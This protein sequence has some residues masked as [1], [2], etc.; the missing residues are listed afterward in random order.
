M[1]IMPDKEGVFHLAYRMR[2]S[3]GFEFVVFSEEYDTIATSALPCLECGK[4]ICD[5]VR[6][7]EDGGCDDRD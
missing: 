7:E 6:L 5:S 2:H 4:P 1:L 3:C